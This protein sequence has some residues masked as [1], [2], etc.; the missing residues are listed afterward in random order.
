MRLIGSVHPEPPPTGGYNLPHD[1]AL[2]SARDLQPAA[3]RGDRRVARHRARGRDGFPAALD[4]RPVRRLQPVRVP[5]RHSLALGRTHLHGAPA[6]G[7]PPACAKSPGRGHDL[8][9]GVAPLAAAQ[10]RLQ[11][12]LD[13]AR[14]DPRL[15]QRRDGGADDPRRRLR[16]RARG[17]A[18]SARRLRHRRPPAARRA[19]ARDATRERGL[20]GALLLLRRP[21][22]ARAVQADLH[23]DGPDLRARGRAGR[24]ALQ[25]QSPGDVRTLHGADGGIRAE[26]PRHRP[27]AHGR[28]RGAQPLR[29]AVQGRPRPARRAA[30]RR[31]RRPAPGRTAP[32]PALRRL[33][34]RA[35]RPQ[36]AGARFPCARAARPAAARRP[37]TARHGPLRLVV[38]RGEPLLVEDWPRAPEQLRK[39]ALETGKETGSIL[40]VP[41][42][43]DGAVIGLVSVQHTEAHVYS[44][45]DLNLR[46]A[47]PA[48]SSG[49]ARLRCPR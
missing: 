41:L 45:A 5:V 7:R 29:A 23:R 28:G 2:P 47:G 33:L 21:R 15:P 38:E 39:R 37:T 4:R 11:P 22:C 30:H 46:G 42:K 13:H 49:S 25:R 40:A 3:R 32:A 48:R 43:H 35:R 27:R 20:H 12:R 36:A 16:L 31:A 8:R 9:G 19:R 17:R 24:A 34:S 14:R 10:P 18:P 6:A 44:T 1:P 26:R